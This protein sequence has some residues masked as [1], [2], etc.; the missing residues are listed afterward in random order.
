MQDSQTPEEIAGYPLPIAVERREEYVRDGF[1]N[2]F[3]RYAGRLPFAEDLVAA[4]YCA[5]DPLTP[6]RIKMLLVAALAYFILP[7]DLVPDIFVGFGF[8]DDATVLAAVLGMI[9]GHLKPE[10]HKLARDVLK[11][12]AGEDEVSG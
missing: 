5:F 6:R 12:D 1:W 7:A 8:T 10:H 11:K 3:S 4:Y 2:K 9:R